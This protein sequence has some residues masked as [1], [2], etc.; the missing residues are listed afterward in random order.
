[1]NIIKNTLAMVHRNE[2]VDFNLATLTHEDK[3]VFFMGDVARADMPQLK[4]FPRG[5]SVAAHLEKDRNGKVDVSQEFVNWVCGTH[6]IS[7]NS[8]RVTPDILTGSQSELLASKVARHVHKMAKDPEHKKFTQTYLVSSNYTLLDGHHGWAAARLHC[9]L[10]GEHHKL[11]VLVLGA[12]INELID[13]A[14]TFTQLVGV[15]SKP[16]L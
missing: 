2:I 11:K 12:G 3:R 16:G 1:M 4:G 8:D 13:H 15:Q 10:T 5:G 7:L 6:Q 14:R 9:M